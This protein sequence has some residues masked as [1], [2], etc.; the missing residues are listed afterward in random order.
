MSA[1]AKYTGTCRSVRVALLVSASYLHITAVRDDYYV[2]HSLHCLMI[3]TGV[4]NDGP[5]ALRM[6]RMAA[7]NHLLPQRVCSSHIRLIQGSSQS[8]SVAFGGEDVGLRVR[9]RAKPRSAQRT[10]SI[11]L[12]L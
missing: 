10:T 11:T 4:D 12:V 5:Y 1:S 7:T 8:R 3:L 2:Q 9:S 6:P